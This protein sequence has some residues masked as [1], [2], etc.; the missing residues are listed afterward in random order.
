M[1]NQDNSAQTPARFPYRHRHHHHY[2]GTE[3]TTSNATA[4][5]E[6]KTSSQQNNH[7]RHSG[8][9]RGRM[10]WSAFQQ[11][12]AGDQPNSPTEAVNTDS[13]ERERRRFR[14]RHFANGDTTTINKN[15]SDP[16][17]NQ[18]SDQ[19]SDHPAGHRHRHGHRHHRMMAHQFFGGP[20]GADCR[21]RS[22]LRSSTSSQEDSTRERTGSG[23]AGYGSRGRFGGCHGR[24]RSTAGASDVNTAQ[25]TDGDRTLPSTSTTQQDYECDGRKRWMHRPTMTGA[26]HIRQPHSHPP[27]PNCHFDLT[28]YRSDGTKA[29]MEDC[30][31]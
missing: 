25:A 28:G 14:H 19:T 16:T 4:S 9:A 22:S 23:R 6:T 18:T 5:T 3:D 15:E 21:T 20:G 7:P 11:T 24:S 27:C 13:Q 1:N 31:H 10:R 26:P 17:S 8:W 12:Q 2:D 29:T 30:C